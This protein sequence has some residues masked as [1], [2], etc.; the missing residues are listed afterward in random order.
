ME[1][2]R[3]FDSL[4][5]Y[6]VL[7]IVF[8]HLAELLNLHPLVNLNLLYEGSIPVTLFFTLSGYVITGLL[9]S[10]H[11]SYGLYLFRR[12][13][14]LVPA[15]IIISLLYLLACDLILDVL[16]TLDQD[17]EKPR[18]VISQRIGIFES[19]QEFWWQ[20]L[21]LRFTPFY[22][23][24]DQILTYS[25]KAFIPPGWSVAIEWQFYLLSPLM[26]FLFKRQHVL[27]LFFA[28]LAFTL[29]KEVIGL[30][31]TFIGKH[32]FGFMV[33]MSSFY[34]IKL[35]QENKPCIKTY[36]FSVALISILSLLFIGIAFGFSTY[37]V[38]IL[39]VPYLIWALFLWAAFSIKAKKLSPAF[40]YIFDNK[41]MFFIG[42]ISYS[43]Y[44]LHMLIIY[45]VLY[46]TAPLMAEVSPLLYFFVALLLTYALAVFSATVSYRY[47]EKPFMNFSR[48]ITKQW[49][50]KSTSN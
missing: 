5:G 41:P 4:R 24:F 34:I 43:L 8:I 1:R 49:R 39:A 14:R 11:E 16:R 26:L 44:L 45:G 33:G 30:K 15:I 35:Y 21:L 47:V 10:R 48:K 3:I 17:L 13:F 23:F 32:I 22:G 20:H 38:I 6:C 9:E 46:L 37:A 36:P 18:E 42:E 40:Q 28:L 29:A 19:T 7:W 2:I 31:G 50:E 27:W 25:T 12:Y